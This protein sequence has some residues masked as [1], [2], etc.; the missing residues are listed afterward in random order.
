MLSK[1]FV[2]LAEAEISAKE[3]VSDVE[4]VAAQTLIV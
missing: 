2:R 3:Y 1:V 4:I